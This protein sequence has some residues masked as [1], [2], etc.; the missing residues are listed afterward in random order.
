MN[1]DEEIRLEVIQELKLDR[2][3]SN[4][5]RIEVTVKDGMVTLSG[6]VDH[7]M[8]R[9][10]ADEVAGRVI[11]VNGVVQ[12]SKVELPSSSMLNDTKIA[13]SAGIAIKHNS[14]IPSNSVKVAVSDGRVKLDGEV[15]ENHQKIE[16]GL[17][18]SKV[19]GVTDVINDIIVKPMVN[20]YAVIREILLTFQHRAVYHVQD[21]H[22]DV[23]NSKVILS[24]IVRAW[25]EKAEA[26]EAVKG[27][28]GVTEVENR[29][30]VTPLLDGKEKP[31]GIV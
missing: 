7:Y 14:L 3:I 18:V 25:I 1:K 26:E 27:M 4:P 16:A 22:V 17:T 2:K 10:V 11:G 15:R 9:L 8:D 24:G 12:E 19:L 20:P 29:L 6:K 23:K 21:I 28:P 5:D 13:R 30:E 31:P